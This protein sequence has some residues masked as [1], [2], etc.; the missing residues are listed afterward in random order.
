MVIKRKTP[1]YVTVDALHN[2]LVDNIHESDAAK[3]GVDMEVKRRQTDPR[4]R[5]SGRD[6]YQAVS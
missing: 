2:L 1:E 6:Q 4:M 5:K 3:I